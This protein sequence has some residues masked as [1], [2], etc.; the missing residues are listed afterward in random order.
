[1]KRKWRGKSVKSSIVRHS[2]NSPKKIGPK[3]KLSGERRVSIMF[4]E[5]KNWF[6][7]RGLG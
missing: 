4:N 2:K 3:S 5:D 7:A 6:V 1:M